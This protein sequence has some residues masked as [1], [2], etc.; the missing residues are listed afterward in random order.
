[1]AIPAECDELEHFTPSSL[2][3]LPVPPVFLLRPASGREG[4]AFQY[5]LRVEGLQYHNDEEVRA[6][7]LR[8][9]KAL[10]SAEDYEPNAA[11]LRAYW[12]LVDQN[13]RPTDTEEQAVSEL[14]ARLSESWS[15]LARMAADNQR[16]I[17]ESMKIAASMFVVGWRGVPI[18]YSR[19]AGRVPLEK[20]DELEAW[21][22]KQEKDAVENG[23]EGAAPTLAF[24][25]LCN[26]AYSR[27]NLTKDEEK[28]SESPPP[29]SPGLNGSTTKP[30]RKTAGA[31]SRTSASSGS[32]RR[33]ISSSSKASTKPH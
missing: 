23:I 33:G 3:N 10:W 19:E 9:L 22:L 30:S 20:L 31:R 6:E 12:E 13:G 15:P 26:A 24:I 32:G 8:G 4:R 18:P 14:S 17:E 28:N 27:L 5:A 7:A 16:L 11:R 29:S 21:L 2:A 25:Q 1:M